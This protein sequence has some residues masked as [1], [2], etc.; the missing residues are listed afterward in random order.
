MFERVGESVNFRTPT[1]SLSSRP[2]GGSADEVCSVSAVLSDMQGPSLLSRD[3]SCGGGLTDRV[4]PKVH[5]GESRG[6]FTETAPA[7]IFLSIY[8]VKK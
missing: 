6:G 3:Y 8:T 7:C 2:T 1:I 5:P 4:W